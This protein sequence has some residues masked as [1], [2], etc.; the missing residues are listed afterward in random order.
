[1][2]YANV[3]IKA[4]AKRVMSLKQ[5]HLKMSKSHPDPKSRILLTDTPEDIN[6]K[7]RLAMTDSESGIS[8]DPEGR[9][10]V[11]NLL[12]IMSH[13]DE[14][15]RSP[16]SLAKECDSLSLRQFKERVSERVISSLAGIKNAYDRLLLKD[17]GCYID[18]VAQKGAERARDSAEETMV[19]VREA[20]GI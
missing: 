5:P 20:V 2:I 3:K 19:L 14:K 6:Q 16:E 4:P 10:G 11:S 18:Y 12:E 13:L 8:Y 1:M 7:I 15:G 9:P 17:D